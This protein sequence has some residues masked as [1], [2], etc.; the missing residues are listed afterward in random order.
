LGLELYGSLHPEAI[1]KHQNGPK[2]FKYDEVFVLNQFG[3]IMMVS[4]LL[5]LSVSWALIREKTLSK[6]GSKSP[7][8]IRSIWFL[9]ALIATALSASG[10]VG[11]ASGIVFVV[12]VG[13]LLYFIYC[14]L[15]MK[16][17][18]SQSNP[19]IVSE[20]APLKK[21]LKRLSVVT[22][23]V[24]LGMLGEISSALVAMALLG[25]DY[26]REETDIYSRK[27]LLSFF[28]LNFFELVVYSS[29]VFDAR[30]S[31]NKN[32]FSFAM[33]QSASGG[34]SKENS[35]EIIGSA[36]VTRLSEIRKESETKTTIQVE[37]NLQTNQEGTKPS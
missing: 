21:V 30:L 13:C 14:F 1:V 29:I 16:K 31:V 24:F 3:V 23:R 17:L 18:L 7:N 22:F 20:Q 37:P 28:F 36:R 11:S 8:I 35:K 5:G 15:L 33:G 2:T 12:G 10:Y 27:S 4:C 25:S 34:G 32:V 9:S 6:G 26:G 19:N